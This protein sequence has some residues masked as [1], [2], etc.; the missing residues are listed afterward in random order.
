M[1]SIIAKDYKRKKQMKIDLEKLVFKTRACLY[2]MIEDHA[3]FRRH[4][5][6]EKS[7]WMDGRISGIASLLCDLIDIL[8]AEGTEFFPCPLNG[9]FEKQMIEKSSK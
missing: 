6:Y 2:E 3:V 1:N 9:E 7:Q 5:H 4:K 8:R